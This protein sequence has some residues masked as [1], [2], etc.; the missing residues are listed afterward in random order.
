ML[1]SITAKWRIRK[2]SGG[3]ASLQEDDIATEYPLTVRLDGEEFATIVCSPTDLEEMIIGFLA[4]EGVIRQAAEIESLRIDEERGFV[5]VEL[6]NKHSTSK[7]EVSKRFIG[8][9]CGKSR[10]FYFHNDARTARTSM[11]RMTISPVQCSALIRLLQ[12]SSGEFK[13]TGGVHNA[14]LCTATELLAVRT[15]IGRHNALDKLFG[16]SLQ[17]RIAITDKIIAF[18]GRLSSEV[19]LKAAKIGVGILL[20]KSA[21]TDLALKLAEDLG[22]TC[23]GFIRGN[24]MNVYTHGHRIVDEQNESEER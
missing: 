18:S 17:Q 2:Y 15:D 23:V 9:C 7:D 5:Y 22:I 14:A 4:S 24:E 13:L 21:P 8:S 1:P 16:F 20:S 3:A 19:V 6:F 10:Q 11:S 12:N